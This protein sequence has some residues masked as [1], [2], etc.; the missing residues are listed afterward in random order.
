[1]SGRCPDLRG[2]P[3]GRGL[4]TC[5]S[6]LDQPLK[7]LQ[8]L[9]AAALAVHT[10]QNAS[11]ACVFVCVCVF[12]IR[13]HLA[14]SGAWQLMPLGGHSANQLPVALP[15]PLTNPSLTQTFLVHISQKS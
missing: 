7:K 15:A 13:I 9:P 8:R 4:N 10:T 6:C 14:R 3:G 11:N 1:M 2:G 5:S 12:S